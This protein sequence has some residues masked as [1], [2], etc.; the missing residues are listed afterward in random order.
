MP[1]VKMN[2]AELIQTIRT[3]E[4]IA[5]DNKELCERAVKQIEERDLLDAEEE[6]RESTLTH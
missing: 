5:R 6:V 2:K 4:K 3:L 1:W